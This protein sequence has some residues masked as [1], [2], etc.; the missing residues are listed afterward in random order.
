[1][2]TDTAASRVAAQPATPAPAPPARPRSRPLPR[3]LVTITALLATLLLGVAGPLAL[4][5]KTGSIHVPHNDTWAFSRTAEIFARTGHIRLFNW[6]AMSLLGAIVPLGPLGRTIAS[7]SCT[8]AALSVVTL[9]AAF[10][11]LRGVTGSRRAAL[12]LLVMASWPCYGL[13][14]TSLMT[15]IPAFAATTLTLALGRRAIERGSKT[16]FALCGLVGLWGFTV[17]EQTIAAT[18]AVLLAA[19][20][21][22]RLRRRG[23]LIWFGLLTVVLGAAAGAFELWRRTLPNGSSPTFEQISR[24]DMSAVIAGFLGGVLLLGLVVSPLVFLVAR[25]STFSPSARA[26]SRRTLL[27]TTVGVLWYGVSFPQNYFLIE[28]AY[29]SAYL[30]HRPDV[31]P[32]TA[33]DLMFPLA[34]VS[35][36]LLVGLAVD[37]MRTLR[38]ELAL[39]LLFTLFGTFLEVFEGE[40]LFDRYIFPM[41]LPTAAMLLREPLRLGLSSRL[42][43]GFAAGVGVFLALVT[44][45]LTANALSYDAANWRVAQQLVASGA[46]SPEHIDAGLDWDGYYSP[47]GAQALAD[48]TSVPGIY[49]KAAALN[50]AHPCY[51]VASRPQDQDDYSFTLVETVPYEKYGLPG[52]HNELFVYRTWVGT[53]H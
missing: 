13:L 16:L 34:I 2:T 9:A 26:W 43:K 24:P 30:G 12:G 53:C 10:D 45:A 4:A 6:N 17:R 32:R 42:R 35:T 28:G 36:S 48:P 8:I 15:D 3:H 22:P 51:V 5:W 49:E 1:M 37:R 14:S 29:S 23:M 18:V 41:A 44:A 21:R 33:W 11:V 19:L 7:Q 25:P 39:F 50:D 31:I 20:L 27:V 40:I 38:P 46:A 52:A 47:D